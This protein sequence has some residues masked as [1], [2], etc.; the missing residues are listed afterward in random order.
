MGQRLR[1]HESAAMLDRLA[2]PAEE[3]ARATA[4]DWIGAFDAAVRHGDG[5]ALTGLFAPDS[6]WRNLLGLTFLFATFSGRDQL[7]HELIGRAG[8][9][10]AKD[11][12]LDVARLVPR[13]ATFAGREVIDAIFTFHTS[14]GPGYGAVRLL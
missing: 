4:E 7:V 8:G 5:S 11:F 6:H 9:V 13:H 14:N 10:A 12:C 2:P 3:T 1:R